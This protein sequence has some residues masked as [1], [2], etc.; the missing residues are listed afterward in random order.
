MET[1][2]SSA[3][4]SWVVSPAVSV[5]SGVSCR[6]GGGLEEQSTEV[7]H[8]LL[9]MEVVLHSTGGYISNL[10]KDERLYRTYMD[11]IRCLL[12]T[13]KLDNEV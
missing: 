13:A 7:N 6:L 8:L 4:G 10:N 11:M 12:Y 5:R 2:W 9:K 1:R 3:R